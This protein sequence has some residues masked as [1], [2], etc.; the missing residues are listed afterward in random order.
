MD[1]GEHAAAC[2][3]RQPAAEQ[4][5]AAAEEKELDEPEEQEE[6]SGL[7]LED[8]GGVVC[9]LQLADRIAGVGGM[10]GAGPPGAADHLGWCVDVGVVDECRRHVGELDEAVPPSRAGGQP[11]CAV[12]SAVGLRPGR[13]PHA[14]A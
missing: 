13:G 2:G 3:H 6:R 12:W 11:I 1:S 9:A 7:L 4:R 5:E 14:E 8:L 10:R